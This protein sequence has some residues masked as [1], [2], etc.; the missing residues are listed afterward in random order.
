MFLLTWHK[1]AY[2]FCL[3]MCSIY[4]IYIYIYA[5][6]IHIYIYIYI[7]SI[8]ILYIL[9]MYIIYMY[10]IYVL[11]VYIYIYIYIHTFIFT[12][13]VLTLMYLFILDYKDCFNFGNAISYARKSYW[14]IQRKCRHRD[15]SSAT[16]TKMQ[17]FCRWQFFPNNLGGKRIHVDHR[18]YVNGENERFF[19]GF[20]AF[21]VLSFMFNLSHSRNLVSSMAFFQK[22]IIKLPQYPLKLLVF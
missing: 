13:P 1:P 5:Y 22:C 16:C 21:V 9:Y 4:Y 17:R 15:K 20:Y 11:H 2:W 6:I 7:Y 19:D 10:Y 12:F 14:I 3:L 8:Y 18:K